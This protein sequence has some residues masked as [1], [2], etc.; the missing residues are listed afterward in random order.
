M[1]QE[2]EVYFMSMAS[3]LPQ[4]RRGLVSCE[5]MWTGWGDPIVNDLASACHDSNLLHVR[6]VHFR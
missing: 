3:G 6:H 5:R 1:F 2:S 4:G